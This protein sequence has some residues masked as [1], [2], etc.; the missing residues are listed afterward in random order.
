MKCSVANGARR[1]SMPI[2]PTLRR[3]RNKSIKLLVI[4]VLIEGTAH[5]LELHIT[6]TSSRGNLLLALPSRRRRSPSEHHQGSAPVYHASTVRGR[7]QLPWYSVRL[8]AVRQSPSCSC[9]AGSRAKK[10]CGHAP[11]RGRSRSVSG[12]HRSHPKTVRKRFFPGSHDPPFRL[13]GRHHWWKHEVGHRRMFD[14]SRA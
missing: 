9:L 13:R 5:I 3:G 12:V 11:G 6:K 1:K 7:F 10:S 14:C 8:S 4:D 2:V